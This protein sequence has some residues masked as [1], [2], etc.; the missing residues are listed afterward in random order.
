MGIGRVARGWR[1]H[2]E[3]GQRRKLLICEWKYRGGTTKT[4]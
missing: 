1:R 4:F 2:Q 3:A